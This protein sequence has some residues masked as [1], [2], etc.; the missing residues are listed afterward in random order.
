MEISPHARIETP[1]VTTGAIA[2]KETP[3]WRRR[4]AVGLGL[5]TLIGVLSL[6]TTSPPAQ[7]AGPD[8]VVV[9]ASGATGEEEMVLRING[10]DTARWPVAK[11]LTSY[12]HVVTSPLEIATLEVAFIND[13]G[14]RDL[15][16]RKV[17]LG[18]T[19]LRSDDRGTTSTGTYVANDGGCRSR[20]SESL[21]LHCNG[22]FAYSVPSG[23]VLGRTAETGPAV[24]VRAVGRSGG[25]QMQI[26]INGKIVASA[27][28]G[29]QWEVV[30][31]ALPVGTAVT[32]AEVQFVNDGTDRDLRVDY[33]EVDGQRFQSESSNTRALGTYVDGSCAERGSSSEW[34]HCSG[35]F[36]YAVADTGTTPTAA[37]VKAT[38]AA[39][40]DP[41]APAADPKKSEAA[42]AGKSE[43]A[44]PVK[45]APAEP[46]EKTPVVAEPEGDEIVVKALGKSGDEVMQ[47]RV[48]GRAIK[49]WDVSKSW[50]KYRISVPDASAI[51]TLEVQFV[52]DGPGRDLRVDYA[53]LAGTKYQSESSKTLAKG[54]H[55]GASGCAERASNSEWLHCSGWFSYPVNGAKVTASVTANNTGSRSTSTSKANT[56]KTTNSSNTSGR[57]SIAQVIDGT[58]G[59]GDGSN[60]NEESPMGRHEASLYLPQGWNW[61]QGPTRNSVWGKLGTGGSRYAEWRCAVIPENGHRPSVPFRINVKNGAYYQFANN[62]WSKGFDV[63]LT[64]GNHGGYLGQA[65]KVNSDPF[66]SGG[67]LMMHFWAGQRKAP[68][69]GQTAEFLTSEVRLQQ[70]DGKTVDLSK[71]KVLFQCGIDYYNT[72]GGQGTKVPGPGIAKYHRVTKDWRPGLWVTLPGNA[73]A[74]SVGDFRTWLQRNTP[75]KVSG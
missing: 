50:D 60:P 25:E 3:S 55:S 59:A 38:A 29:S 6:A 46:V 28:V 41:I 33:L 17:D 66:S 1:R 57:Y 64:G 56:P 10:T 16:V 39:K 48:N 73:P 8:Q 21:V 42:E 4:V 30:R 37:P 61:A 13:D 52:N 11:G 49:S 32:S 62:S 43:E 53:K 74:G 75:P 5:A 7:A 68:K 35:W 26:R 34:L 69:G 2:S 22:T 58:I 24:S 14:P 71:V 45:T 67:P 44:E 40:D 36:R 63:D 47:L 20:A 72:T 27:T 31:A 23:T 70:P 19:I 9:R 15:T 18:G 54:S 51:K 12:T 65:G